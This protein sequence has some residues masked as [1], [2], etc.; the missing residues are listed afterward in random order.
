MIVTPELPLSVK[1][2][3][4]A[5]AGVYG[6]DDRPI[7]RI[8]T[9][10][11]E[12]AAGD[13][14]FALPGDGDGGEAYVAEAQKNGAIAVSKYRRDGV[15]LVRDVAEALLLLASEYRRR[16]PALKCVIGVTGSVG[17]TTTKEFIAA[18]L[19]EKYRTHATAGNY[20]NGL[21]VPLTVLSAPAKTE[22]LIVE[23]GMNHKGE[24]APLSACVHPNL[25]VITNIGTA[26]IGNLGSR[27]M[28]AEAKK[29]ILTGMNGGKVVVPAEEPLLAD[30]PHRMTVS[31]RDPTADFFLM[32]KTMCADKSTADF[33]CGE[34]K[35][36]N[37]SVF[38]PG[39][40]VLS[41]LAFSVSVATLLG[42]S[43]TEIRRG[44]SSIK[45]DRIRQSVYKIGKLTVF[46]DA[47]NAS[48]ESVSA[49]IRTLSLFREKEKSALIG[50]MLELG[51]RT[52]EC[53]EAVGR[54]LADEGFSKLY[55]FGVY[56]QFVAAGAR[57]SGK[58]TC[59][60][61]ENTDPLS[62]VETAR[63]ILSH[64]GDGEILLVKGSRGA[65]LER[66]LE[67]MKNITEGKT[68]A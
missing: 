45:S 57:R 67:I 9:D 28:I 2:I 48:P 36:G 39:M 6:G 1:N 50:D 61:Y 12:A 42:L 49:A 15:L 30:V 41:A 23:M 47:Y 16:L 33:F 27:E 4:D 68:N 44:I 11:R 64:S 66:I 17:K 40:P 3:A 62:P 24:I 7:F 43:D 46:D 14:F 51:C 55:L 63:R 34:R 37:L 53:H 10:S 54:L 20:N 5:V 19:S 32:P 29:E 13:L 26:H 21:G 65:H 58:S 56:A 25:A 59:V 31:L 18:I 38:A 35:I 52:E 8:V 60:V 22:V